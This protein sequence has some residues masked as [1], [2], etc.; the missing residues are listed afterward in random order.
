MSSCMAS[1]SSILS[2]RFCEILEVLLFKSK[3]LVLVS[4]ESICIFRWVISLESVKFNFRL[5]MDSLTSF[6]F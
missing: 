1:I 2:Q 4:S 3:I 6:E 5:S